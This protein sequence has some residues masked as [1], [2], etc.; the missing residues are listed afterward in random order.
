MAISFKL[1]EQVAYE[2]NRKAATTLPD[3]YVEALRNAREEKNSPLA[4]YVLDSMIEGFGI[5]ET[6]QR[7]VCADVGCPR[8][9]VKLGNEVALEQGLVSV[10]TAIRR[11]TAKVTADLA[12]RSNRCHPLTREN[13]GNNV[14]VL[15][16]N[17][18]YSVEPDADW[19]ELTAVHKGGGFHTDFRNLFAG[20]GIDAIKRF[21][22]EV[23]GQFG[24]RGL[25]CQPLIG[26]VGIGGTKDMALA[27]AKMASCL[28]LV[29]DRHPDPVVAKL[30]EE[31]LALANQSGIGVMGFPGS[32]LAV[33]VHVEIAYVHSAFLTT[34]ISHFCQAARRASARINSDATVEYR[35][36]PQWFTPYYRRKGIE[37]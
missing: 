9:Y 13:P 33:D 24:P 29:G 6:E 11:G 16:P 2:L 30:E 10:E 20:E 15:A 28:R 1:L 37:W 7:P 23:I 36:D 35:T 27:M 26:G 3:D 22:L 8:F 14:G 12:M 4:Q 25:A 19:I 31:L 32:L 34:G 17:V 5:A 21:F 18:D